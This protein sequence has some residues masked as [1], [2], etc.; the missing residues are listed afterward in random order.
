M[1]KT[2]LYLQTCKY[3]PIKA[4]LHWLQ[5]FNR[6]TCSPEQSGPPVIGIVCLL[7]I[8]LNLDQTFRVPPTT[9]LSKKRSKSNFLECDNSFFFFLFFFAGMQLVQSFWKRPSSLIAKMS[10][11]CWLEMQRIE[12][13][14]SDAV[15]H[16]RN[17]ENSFFSAQSSIESSFSAFTVFL[18]FL[19]ERLFQ[20]HWFRIKVSLEGVI[21]TLSW[22]KGY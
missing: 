4:L 13:K 2:A 22:Y 8:D 21:V 9:F 12:K 19:S 17:R 7:R 11:S 6:F 14:D 3:R 16:E 5:V 18:I 15:G 1:L 10:L 20:S